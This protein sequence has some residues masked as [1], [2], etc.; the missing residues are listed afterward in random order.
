MID[1]IKSIMDYY[2]LTSAQFA[3]RIGF[4]RSALSHVLSGRNNPS[5]D[6][7]LKI[8]SSFP[9]VNLDWLTLG[10][11]EEFVNSKGKVESFKQPSLDL[12]DMDPHYSNEEK[13][14]AEDKTKAIK[15]KPIFTNSIHNE[16]QEEI[17]TA[18]YLS[19][20]KLKGI[21][22]IILLYDDGSFSEHNPEK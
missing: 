20:N 8:K 1:R 4:Q 7:V 16:S 12:D 9:D 10:K 15:D 17:K 3:D 2:N 21:R 14:E 18:D 13:L 19:V 22:K 6:F 5:L 11:G